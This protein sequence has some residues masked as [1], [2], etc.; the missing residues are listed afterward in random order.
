[1]KVGSVVECIDNEG[2]EN[3]V[4]LNTPYTISDIL[5]IGTQT[6]GVNNITFICGEIG[7]FIFGIDTIHPKYCF[8]IAFPIKN[9]RELMSNA[10]LSEILNEI[11]EPAL[12]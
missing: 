11:F 3:L 12:I 10:Q 9:F 4:K 2:F 5:P 6:K 1:M 7:V 8:K